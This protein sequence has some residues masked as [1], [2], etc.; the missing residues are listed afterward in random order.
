M[1]GGSDQGLLRNLGWR[2]RGG[3]LFLFVW[4]DFIQL[5][6]IDRQNVMKSFKLFGFFRIGWFICKELGF[7]ILL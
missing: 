7:Y 6:K 5:I 4:I 2:Q 3:N 1:G